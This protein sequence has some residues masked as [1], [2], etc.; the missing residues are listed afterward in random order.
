MTRKNFEKTSKL[1]LP[2]RFTEEEL[3]AIGL[4]LAATHVKIG[5]LV[6]QKKIEADRMKDLIENATAE[7]GRL[8]TNRVNGFE[9]RYVDCTTS[10]DFRRSTKRTVRMDTG[11]VVSEGP[12]T[13][14][15]LKLA[16]MA[17]DDARE[18]QTE[19]QTQ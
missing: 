19:E 5:E 6:V 2:V 10:Y 13:D 4:Q 12:M 11:E 15:E 16:Q 7:A 9:Q 18:E 1:L 3:Q 8:A 17:F 14:E